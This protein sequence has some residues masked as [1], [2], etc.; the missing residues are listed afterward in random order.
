MEKPKTYP[1]FVYKHLRAH[2]ERFKGELIECECGIAE[3]EAKQAL[4]FFI[5]CFALYKGLLKDVK[6]Q[7][8]QLYIKNKTSMNFSSVLLRD[9]FNE[10]GY[11]YK[12]VRDC[13][14]D[15]GVFKLLGK[16]WHD[17][18]LGSGQCARYEI[19]LKK[20]K[21]GPPGCNKFLD[22]FM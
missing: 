6:G 20:L 13:V 17:P 7:G 15:A 21:I 1:T 12:A 16:G 22:K 10:L 11:D 9:V 5:T 19:G 4:Q 8:D 3:E 2:F 18:M 14:K